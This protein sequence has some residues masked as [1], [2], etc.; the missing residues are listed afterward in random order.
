MG[1]ME[2]FIVTGLLLGLTVSGNSAGSPVCEIQIEKMKHGMGGDNED[3]GF[4]LNAANLTYEPNVA[5][6]LELV[7]EESFYKGILIYVEPKEKLK[8]RVGSFAPVEQH[9]SIHHKCS[10]LSYP[11]EPNSILTNSNADQKPI[12]QKFLWTPKEPYGDV[13]VNVLVVGR[14][15]KNWQVLPP[16]T[17][18]MKQ[19]AA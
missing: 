1:L 9:L 18:T 14:S 10:L 11:S 2:K 3:L 7:G 16:V 15:M 6:P 5:I 13:S 19:N 17:L 4:R 8:S 12:P